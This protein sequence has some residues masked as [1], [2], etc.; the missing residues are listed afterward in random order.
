MTL[1]P[2]RHLG[3]IPRTANTPHTGASVR[4][5]GWH[6]CRGER[7]AGTKDLSQVAVVRCRPTVAP[8][9]GPRGECGRQL[10]AFFTSARILSSTAAVNSFSAKEVGHRAPSSS[11]ASS[12]KPS[13]AYRELNFCALWKK[14]MTLP[15]LA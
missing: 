13:V 15:S 8:G 14:Q 6:N 10:T 9:A 5:K 11:L 2:T 4:S 3:R 7:R 12:L 1:G